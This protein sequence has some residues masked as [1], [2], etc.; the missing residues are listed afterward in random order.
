[1]GLSKAIERRLWPFEQP[2]R[3]FELKAD[4]FYALERW[5]DRW[6][7][8]DLASQSAAAL[9]QLVRL[10]EHQGRAILSASKQFPAVRINYNLLPLCSDI[11][12]IH[13]RI[14][15]AFSWSTKV[16]GSIEPFWLWVEDH[17]G[18]TIL[19]FSY[20]LFRPTTNV[21]D[22]EFVISIPGGQPPPSVTARFV[23]DRW[24]GAED[25][26]SFS[27]DS[28]M[29]PAPCVVHSPRLDLPYLSLAA[30]KSQSLGHIFS[31]LLTGFNNIQ[32]Q[33]LWSLVHTRL[34]A[35]V[36]A[37]TGCG[38]SVLGQIV[39]WYV[40]VMGCLIFY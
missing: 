21:L 40:C 1:V 15:R 39:I 2:L 11:L 34:H 28:L 12:K 27:L 20:L 7:V 19:Q 18:L 26:L 6:S 4:V 14:E 25:E 38:K 10:N 23:S 29:M 9:G 32:T 8:A 22:A 36:C 17:D 5:A 37:P 13:L 3:Q 24:I 33:A 35:L 31:K 16:H 30:L